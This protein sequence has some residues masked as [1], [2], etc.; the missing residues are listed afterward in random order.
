MRKGKFFTSLDIGL[1]PSLCSLF[2]FGKAPYG[3]DCVGGG[4]GG[5]FADPSGC[6]A[7]RCQM[8]KMRIA[9]AMLLLKMELMAQKDGEIGES[10][11]KGLDNAQKGPG[12]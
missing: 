1:S 3:R 8:R 7:N 2:R 11:N 12:Y 4:C 9:H 6:A 5:V 10:D